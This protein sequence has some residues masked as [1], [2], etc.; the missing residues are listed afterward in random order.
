[1]RG[2]GKASYFTEEK[3]VGTRISFRIVRTIGPL[4]SVSARFF[5]H[6]VSA[7]KAF[8]FVSRSARESHAIR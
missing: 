7:W 2:R 8:H 3:A 5:C 4:A 1:M 6:S